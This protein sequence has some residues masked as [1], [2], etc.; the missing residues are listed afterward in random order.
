M[1]E[2]PFDFSQTNRAAFLSEYE[3]RVP[4]YNIAR[5]NLNH[6][7]E[8]LLKMLPV[9]QRSRAKVESGRVKQGPRLWLK[10]RKKADADDLETPV[11]DVEGVFGAVHDVVGTRITCNTT[12][13]VYAVASHVESN[14]QPEKTD[15]FLTLVE[16]RDYLEKPKD[17]GYRGYHLLVKVPVSRAGSVETVP[18]EIQV[19]TLLQNAWG[20]LTHEDTYKPGMEVPELAKNLSLRLATV[21]KVMDELAVDIRDELNR[22]IGDT[23]H[24]YSDG[25]EAGEMSEQFPSDADRGP[26]TVGR[27]VPPPPPRQQFR[28]W[29]DSLRVGDVVE[30][31][32]VF[33]EPR[34]GIVQTRGGVNGILHYSR[35]ADF[36]P[37]FVDVEE[38]IQPGDT[39]LVEVEELDE[40]LRRVV[41][42]YDPNL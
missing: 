6:T 40:G 41:F 22:V 17:S 9:S 4:T 23:G 19:R 38:Y 42:G 26:S 10:V 34:Y 24:V 18:C 31:E 33:V 35:I 7:L 1:R 21:L 12:T 13:D 2:T 29:D 39:I 30:G 36:H 15:G 11:V 8:E 16:S 27:R 3:S 20:E 14:C 37:G 5:Q 32:V 25:D 28:P